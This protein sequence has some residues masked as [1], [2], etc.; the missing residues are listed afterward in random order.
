MNPKELQNKI[1]ALQAELKGVFDAHRTADG[2]DMSV[3]VIN[4]V[5]KR[6]AELK[7]LNEQYVKAKRIELAAQSNAD[8]FEREQ[9]VKRLPVSQNGE[10]RIKTLGQMFVESNALKQKG[11]TSSNPDFEVKTV[12]SS[13]AGWAPI[14]E[15]SNVVVPYAA[16]ALTLLERLPSMPVSIG[17]SGYR[18][19]QETTFTNN[20]AEL[21]EG[22]GTYGEAAL[23]LTEQT[24]SIRKIGVTLPVTDEQIQDVNG[25]E[26]YL[27]QRLSYML[28]QRLETQVV[29]GDGNAPNIKGM[30]AT[31]S[32]LTQARG[33]MAH[34]DAI[35]KGITKLAVSGFCN[36]SLLVIHPTD[37]E[38]IRLAQTVDGVYLLGSPALGSPTGQTLFGL[39][40]VVTTAA[41]QGTAILVDEGFLAVLLARGIEFEVTNSHA[42]EFTSGVQRIRADIRAG[43]AVYRAPAIC[44]V[45]GL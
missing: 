11:V 20:A 8:Y 5:E 31:S 18:Y 2:F 1:A 25:L 24:A 39:P 26:A 33:T 42:S 4:E 29:S 17:S 3:D 35:F 19:M 12:F 44:T 37:Y 23:A 16:R 43:L 10:A 9:D 6:E 13:S 28:N 38:T 40:Y 21:A 22:T 27:D 30:T 41:T 7:E 32:I 14:P 45:T 36:A 34:A 15:R